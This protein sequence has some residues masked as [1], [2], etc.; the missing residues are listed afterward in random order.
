M[1]IMMMNH[2]NKKKNDKLF[3]KKLNEKQELS[4]KIDYKNLNYNFTRN[5][6]VQ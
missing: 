1:M 4:K 6:A 5:L 2:Q 3:D